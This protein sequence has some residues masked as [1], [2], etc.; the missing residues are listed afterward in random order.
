MHVDV[1]E[2]VVAAIYFGGFAGDIAET[3]FGKRV[4]TASDVRESLAEAFEEIGRS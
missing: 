4:M 2:T 3:K 1:F